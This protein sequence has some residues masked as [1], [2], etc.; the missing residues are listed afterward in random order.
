MQRYDLINLLI[1][2]NGYKTYLEI[3]VHNGDC[4][5]RITCDIKDSVDPYPSSGFDKLP[6]EYPVTYKL[7]S[8][9]FFDEIA[10]KL[11]YKY[12]II[13]IDGL[14]LSEQ[15]DK[16]VNNSLK[17]LSNHG[18]IIMH[19]CNPPDYSVQVVPRVSEYWSGDVWKSIVKLKHTRPD[20]N[21][22]VID[23]DTGLGVITKNGNPERIVSLPDEYLDWYYFDKNRRNLLSIV[24]PTQFLV[25]LYK[26]KF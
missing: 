4:F 17:Y 2:E 22:F 15:T 23:S 20:L 16:D 8:D 25:S 11:T 26:N 1:K 3:G 5:K 10:P 18:T 13:F 7:T 24:T 21:V 12:D 14:H 9:D 19:D 6:K